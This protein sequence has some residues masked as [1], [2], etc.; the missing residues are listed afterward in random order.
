MKWKRSDIKDEQV[1]EACNEYH[2]TPY[3]RGGKNEN[4]VDILM[5]MTGAPL[6]VVY[7]KLYHCA[8]RDLIDY[9]VSVRGAWWNE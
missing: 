8:D 5:R 7:A 2:N 9:G 1:M 4:V 3:I 6:K